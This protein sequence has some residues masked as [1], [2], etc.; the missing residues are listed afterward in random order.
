MN[1]MYNRQPACP[2]KYYWLSAS[3]EV[4]VTY[5]YCRKSACNMLTGLAVI[6]RL[7]YD[8]KVYMS[9]NLFILS[10]KSPYI[11]SEKVIKSNYF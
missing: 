8:N 3:V 6:L 11:S 1:S 2:N 10:V 4:S 7:K 5:H 9:I